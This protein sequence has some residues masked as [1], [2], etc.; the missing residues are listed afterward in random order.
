MD[1]HDGRRVSACSRGWLRIAGAAVLLSLSGCSSTHFAYNHLDWVAERELSRYVDLEPGQESL[2]ERSFAKLHA[3]HRRSELPLYADDLQQIARNLDQPLTE[4]QL[5]AWLARYDEGFE[6]MLARVAPAM[7]ELGRS[8]SDEQVEEL[9]EELDDRIADYR[10]RHVEA[11]LEERRAESQRKFYKNLRR[12]IGEPRAE[13][14]ALIR[15]WYARRAP[16]GEAWL[17]QRRRWRD[18][19]AKALAHR[20]QPRFCGEL[21]T[22]ILRPETLWTPQQRA[23]FETGKAEWKDLIVRLRATL[24]PGQR[25]YLRAK[26]EGLAGD[27]LALS[28]EPVDGQPAPVAQAAAEP[29]SAA[30]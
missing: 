4:A 21:E 15:D 16:S 18:A 17:E 14:R 10:R 5:D 23:V 28:V 3:W 22:L 12:W 25:E 30:R 8:L 29:G 7:C 1:D 2:F 11:P 20:D 13:Q 26:V 9:L 27:L 6:R 19:L 24:T